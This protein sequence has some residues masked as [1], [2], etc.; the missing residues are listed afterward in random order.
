MDEGLQN[1]KQVFHEHYP[2]VVRKI[3]RIVKDR[4][5]AEDLA[6]EVFLK[7]YEKPPDDLRKIKPWLHRVS[8]HI[9]YDYFRKQKNIKGAI[10]YEDTI[11]NPKPTPLMDS[12][13]ADQEWV[14]ASLERLSPRDRKALMLQQEGYNYGEIARLLKVNQKIVGSILMRAKERFKKNLVSQEDSHGL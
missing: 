7:L 10:Q 6:Q 14:R 2:W 13:L 3:Q 9:S 11:L 5:T 8:T 4:T 1:F 12:V